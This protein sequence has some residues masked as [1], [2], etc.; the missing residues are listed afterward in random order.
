MSEGKKPQDTTIDSSDTV[1]LDEKNTRRK[2]VTKIVATAGVAVAMSGNWNKP[3]LS[4]VVLPAH[5]KMTNCEPDDGTED[6]ECDGL[7]G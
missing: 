3:I 5:A 6:G 2:A 4:S 7:P 1:Q